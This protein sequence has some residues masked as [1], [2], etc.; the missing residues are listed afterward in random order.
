M[1]YRC[2]PN[3]KCFK[4]LPSVIGSSRVAQGR[5]TPNFF[6]TLSTVTHH[7]PICRPFT[8]SYRD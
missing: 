5:S 4:C 1:L 7:K 6:V 2:V 8:A 3:E